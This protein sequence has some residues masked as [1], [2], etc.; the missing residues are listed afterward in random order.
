MVFTGVQ[1]V[2]SYYGGVLS[3]K[4]GTF[5]ALLLSFILGFVSLVF[6][7]FNLWLAFASLGVFTVISLNAIRGY[8]S[9]NALSKSFVYG[10]F[11]AGTAVFSASGALTIGYIWK[12]YGFESVLVFSQSGT[13]SMS[14]LLIL[15]KKRIF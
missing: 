12:I 2:V 5:K 14:I 8:I 7:E 9:K 1:T 6:A 11:Y 10:V 4:V 15:F 13:L 3:D